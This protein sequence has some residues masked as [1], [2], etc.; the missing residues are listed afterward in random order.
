MKIEDVRASC[1]RLQLVLASLIQVKM[2]LRDDDDVLS[3]EGQTKREIEAM[4]VR[5]KKELIRAG[6]PV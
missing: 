2:F 1:D 4:C 5:I 3:V 6:C